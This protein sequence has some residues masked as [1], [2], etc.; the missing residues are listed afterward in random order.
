MLDI[1]Q[2]NPLKYGFNGMYVY[3]HTYKYIYICTYTHT[4]IYHAKTPLV[5]KGAAK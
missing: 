1:P 4:Y 2:Q 3:T 5:L